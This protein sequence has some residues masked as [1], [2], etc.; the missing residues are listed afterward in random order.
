VELVAKADPICQRADHT[1]D[2]SNISTQ[3]GIAQ[4][5]QKIA[6]QEHQAATELASLKPPASLSNDW[7]T[8]VGAYQ[9]VAKDMTEL[10]EHAKAK[11]TLTIEAPI[12]A[13]LTNAQND[14]V[15]AAGQDGFANCAKY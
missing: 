14:R 15:A 4:N 6:A 10:G 9:T 3:Q 2:S 1:F 12:I 8:I 13:S 7:K 5:A 11:G